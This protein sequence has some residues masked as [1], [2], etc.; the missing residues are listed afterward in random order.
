LSHGRTTLVVTT[1]ATAASPTSTSTAVGIDIAA[2]IATGSGRSITAW[3]ERFAT[4]AMRLTVVR[5]RG[6]IVAGC[7]GE[8]LIAIGQSVAELF[9]CGGGLLESVLDGRPRGRGFCRRSLG[10]TTLHHL[11]R[12]NF[13]T[14]RPRGPLRS[15]G[16][17]FSHALFPT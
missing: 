16:A 8:V 9:P 2:V 14:P 5:D 13:A 6:D 11:L 12:D 10:G 15:S 4:L 7:R 17:F 3:F 1:T